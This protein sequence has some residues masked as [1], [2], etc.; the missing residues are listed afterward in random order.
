MIERGQAILAV[1]SKAMSIVRLAK[2][3][4]SFDNDVEALVADVWAIG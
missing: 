1:K 2:T 4:G 3:S